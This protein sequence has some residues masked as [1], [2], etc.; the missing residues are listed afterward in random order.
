M[1]LKESDLMGNNIFV[2]K[3]EI[4]RDDEPCYTLRVTLRNDSRFDQT[5]NMYSLL[6]THTKDLNNNNIIY[7]LI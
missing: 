5:A 4:K 3:E 2:Y 6:K 7:G 1:H